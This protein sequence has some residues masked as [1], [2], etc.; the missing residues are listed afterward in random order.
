MVGIVI[1][2]YRRREA[3][4]QAL[5]S[6][7]LQTNKD[8]I[9]IVVDD[10]SPEPLEDV[11]REFDGKLNYIYKYAE[12]NG[13]PGAA[14]QL[15]LEE[16]YE[17]G[18]KY[19]MFLDSDDM[20]YPQTVQRLLH[21]I[22]ATGCSMISTCIWQEHADGRGAII[23]ADNETWLH[24]KIFQT[25]YLKEYDICF[26]KLRTNEDVT[27]NLIASQC[28]PKKGTCNEVL[29][30][31]KYNKNS[32]TR[33]ANSPLS[34]ISTDYISAL[35]YVSKYMMDKFGKITDQVL[36]D[37]FA[38]YNHYQAGLVLNLITD[39]I[40]EQVRYLLQIPQVKEALVSEEVLTRF[41]TIP[42]HY[43]IYNK[44]VYYFSQ[45]FYQWLKKFGAL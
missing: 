38:I 30:L 17:L 21:E 29:Y 18:V 45:T 9:V 10:H 44:T 20:L 14:R 41:K 4:Y 42:N 34:M 40:I 22:E 13:G 37:I 5:L 25:A 26:P 33:D 3:L 35:Y 36:I 7:E 28:A 11:V 43:M 8:F 31:F 23:P 24:G 6:L 32:I 39:E 16:C 27:F 15:G 1:P 12:V 2:A 19:V